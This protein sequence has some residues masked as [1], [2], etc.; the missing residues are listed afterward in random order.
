MN[1]LV[2]VRVP[3]KLYS[4]IQKYSKEKGYKN[5]QEFMTQATRDKLEKIKKQEEVIREWNK[6]KGTMKVKR[7]SKEEL[8][9]LAMEITPEDS[10]EFL[11]KYNFDYIE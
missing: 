11:R 6:L 10:D 9:R 8:N 5:V 3:E 7:L 4:E 1:K 2:N